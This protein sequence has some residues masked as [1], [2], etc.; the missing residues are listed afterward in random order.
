MSSPVSNVID[1]NAARR[2]RKKEFLFENETRLKKFLCSFISRK[3]DMN[4]CTLSHAYLHYIASEN[5]ESWDYSDFRE[6]VGSAIQSI[7]GNDLWHEI[8]REHWFQSRF[9]S[10]EEIIDR[11]TTEFILAD[12]VVANQ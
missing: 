12:P 7:Y 3:I 2:K 4:F 5:E 11:T 1:M 10:I 8:T 9:L 6:K